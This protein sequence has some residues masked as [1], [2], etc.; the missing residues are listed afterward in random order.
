MK[1][2]RAPWTAIP[3]LIETILLEPNGDQLKITPKGD[4]AGNAECG[5]RQQEVARYR[6]PLGPNKAGCGGVQPAVLAV[7]ERG[8][9]A[10]SAGSLPSRKLIEEGLHPS[11]SQPGEEAFESR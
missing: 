5:H 8:G 4:L 11:D 1:A 10:A 6:R 2:A 7:V 3:A 9:I